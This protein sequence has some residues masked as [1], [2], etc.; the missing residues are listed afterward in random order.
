MIGIRTGPTSRASQGRPGAW[1]RCERRWLGLAALTVGPVDMTR[2]V[3]VLKDTRLFGR[4]S[5]LK[6]PAAVICWWEL[7][8][9]AYNAIVGLTGVVTVAALLGIADY[10]ERNLGDPIGMP[11]PPIIAL[12]AILMYGLFANVFYTL[13]WLSELLVCWVWPKRMEDYG[14]L[15]FTAG[16]AFSVCL[17]LLPVLFFG[18]VVFL[19][20]VVHSL[21]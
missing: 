14:V 1:Q 10:A 3:A 5:T 4:R 19:M 13:G 15:V 18:M 9:I 8:R 2:A 7:R 20:S 21:V 12:L 11:D 16:T 6:S 17:T